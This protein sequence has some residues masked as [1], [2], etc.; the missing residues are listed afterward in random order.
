VQVIIH[1]CT[2]VHR[3]IWSV[4]IDSQE[5]V[6]INFRLLKGCM[7]KRHFASW[8]ER[9][10]HMMHHAAAAL[11]IMIMILKYQRRSVCR[12]WS[13]ERLPRDGEVDYETASLK[14]VCGTSLAYVTDCIKLCKS[15]TKITYICRACLQQIIW[16]IT[17][18]NIS[19][20]TFMHACCKTRSYKLFI[21]TYPHV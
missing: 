18:I 3:D 7:Q 4:L 12:R 2:H 5:A 6:Q 17:R 14:S 9:Q 21:I 15:S 19:E 20:W 10:L 8:S 16:E 13:M 1:E 11:V